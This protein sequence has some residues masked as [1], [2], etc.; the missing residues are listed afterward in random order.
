MI[1]GRINQVSTTQHLLNSEKEP[2]LNFA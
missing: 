1:A 2:L